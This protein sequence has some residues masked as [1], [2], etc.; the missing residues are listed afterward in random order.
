MELIDTHA[1]LTFDELA[2]DLPAVLQ[3]SSEAGVTQWITI[4]TDPENNRKAAAL[5]Q[6]HENMFAAVGFHPHY[7]KDITEADI[8]AMRQLAREEK[9]VAI[10]EVGLDF[11]YNFS[12]QD[13]QSRIFREQLTLAADLGLPVVVH[14]RNAFDEVVAILDAFAGALRHV[15]FHCYSGT[16]EQVRMLLDRG[17]YISFTGIVTFKKSDEARAAALQTPLERMMIETDCPYISPEPV[18]NTRPC[19][20]AMLIHTARKIAE[21]HN[22][23][24]ADFAEAVTRTSRAFFNLPA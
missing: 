12:E 11:H 19:E 20:P 10:G 14:C 8:Q 6:R 23:A 1:H 9:V 18:R 13:A 7:A 21:L 22:M 3:R 2:A 17:W 15:V 5:A 16:A 4:G 24:L